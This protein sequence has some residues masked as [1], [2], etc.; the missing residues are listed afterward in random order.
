MN[1]HQKMKINCI[2]LFFFII[3]AVSY[4]Q[5][6]DSVTPAPVPAADGVSDV[7]ETPDPDFLD[8]PTPTMPDWQM[9]GDVNLD[10]KIDIIDALLVAQYYVGIDPEDFKNPA[11]ANVNGDDKIDII[12][13]LLIAQYYVGILTDFL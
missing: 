6:P 7:S 9:N 13:A 5:I 10:N 12:D 2:L 4:A 1:Q 8:E 3:C 11:V